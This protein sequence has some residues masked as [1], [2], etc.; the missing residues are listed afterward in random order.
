MMLFN[1]AQE[2][3][4][5][6]VFLDVDGVVY[7]GAAYDK[8]H[9]KQ[10]FLSEIKSRK[11]ITN[12]IPASTLQ[13][14][15][16]ADIS[17]ALNF[18]TQALLNISALCKKY[19]AK[20]VISSAWRKDRSLAELKAL[21]TIAAYADLLHKE[22]P[23]DVLDLLISTHEEYNIA[24][25]IID[26][27][28]ILHNDRGE[29]ITTWINKNNINSF[30]VLDDDIFDFDQRFP[31]NFVYCHHLFSDD[32]LFNQADQIFKNEFE[33]GK[34]ADFNLKISSC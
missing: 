22:M 4:H 3:K 2:I 18:N 32:L 7:K 27:T 30:V 8:K 14:L 15:N 34:I 23:S 17:A 29:E 1:E 10:P 20:I 28:P 6:I 31:K 11:I 19:Q 33:L 21:F 26:V 24:K 9:L 5:N 16:V 12:C 13:A 25:Y